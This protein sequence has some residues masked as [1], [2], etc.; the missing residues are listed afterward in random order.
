MRQADLDQLIKTAQVTWTEVAT[1]LGMSK[2]AAN[3][4]AKRELNGVLEDAAGDRGGVLFDEPLGT[5]WVKG[6]DP[7]NADEKAIMATI[8]ACSVNFEREKVGLEDVMWLWDLSHVERF[9]EI[10]SVNV[11]RYAIFVHLLQTGGSF[12][13]IEQGAEKVGLL[14]QK[15]AP[16]YDMCHPSYYKQD[17]C[18][19]LPY[20]LSYVVNN[21]Y[22]QTLAKKGLDGLAEMAGSSDCV[23][24][25]ARRL[26]K[27]GKI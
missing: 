7:S 8:Q 11:I 21:W 22:L 18:H 15:Y 5:K 12:D 27:A 6:K 1:S 10:R 16:S 3:Q 26:R 25:E 17:P 13:S 14:V 4:L 9:I 24:A 20:E 23:N 2:E 19:P